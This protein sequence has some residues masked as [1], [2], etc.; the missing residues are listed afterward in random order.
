MNREDRINKIKESNKIYIDTPK[1]Q[2]GGQQCGIPTYPTIVKNDILDVKISIGF[3]KSN[4][5]NRKLALE[6]IDLLCSELIK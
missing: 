6:I 2:L 1:K 5:K 3:F 4:H